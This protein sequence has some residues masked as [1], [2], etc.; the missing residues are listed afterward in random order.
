MILEPQY[1]YISDIRSV[2]HIR[3]QD[4]VKKLVVRST[5]LE[6]AKL[7]KCSAHI[8]SYQ[9][10]SSFSTNTFVSGLQL[11]FGPL[12]EDAVELGGEVECV[13]QSQPPDPTSDW[14]WQTSPP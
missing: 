6:D 9:F 5:M 8:Q 13:D 3:S 11:V 14:G 12:D 2:A 7:R 4:V 1:L 10:Q